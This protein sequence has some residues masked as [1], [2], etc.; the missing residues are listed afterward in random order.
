MATYTSSVFIS[1][2]PLVFYNSLRLL[3]DIPFMI[4]TML[5]FLTYLENIKTKE[6]RYLFFWALSTTLAIYF[7]F[8]GFILIIIFFSHT[9]FLKLRNMP[10]CPDKKNI[11]IFVVLVALFA[12]G[13][14]GTCR[15]RSAGRGARRRIAAQYRRTQQEADSAEKQT[16]SRG[17][18][19]GSV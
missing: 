19:R 12:T 9:I 17:P 18:C 5:A 11:I 15:G 10:E 3:S 13:L 1:T 2:L 8:T 4:V 6:K 16:G 14:F 7:R